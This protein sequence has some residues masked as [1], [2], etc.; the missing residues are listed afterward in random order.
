MTPTGDLVSRLAA[1]TAEMGNDLTCAHIATGW[2]FSQQRAAAG[3]TEALLWQPCHTPT[4]LRSQWK[5]SH[6]DRL[7]KALQGMR[8]GL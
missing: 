1:D 6:C 4:R 3:H 2:L 5:S 8:S 7:W